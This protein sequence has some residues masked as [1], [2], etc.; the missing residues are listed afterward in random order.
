[1][2]QW[3]IITISSRGDI[4]SSLVDDAPT[5][6]SLTKILGGEPFEIPYFIEYNRATCVAYCN[7]ESQDPINF[8]ATRLWRENLNVE[9]K[10]PLIEK[11][12]GSLVVVIKVK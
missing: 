12:R 6:G 4:D 5:T 10:E 11:V 8:T 1:M 7:Q 3:K 2:A 9:T